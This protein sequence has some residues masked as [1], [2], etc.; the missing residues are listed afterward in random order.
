MDTPKQRRRSVVRPHP[1][2]V[3]ISCCFSALGA[4]CFDHTLGFIP[5]TGLCAMSAVA[6]KLLPA[7]RGEQVRRDEAAD[8]EQLQTWCEHLKLPLPYYFERRSDFPPSFTDPRERA[9]FNWDT[10]P[11]HF[12][13]RE[14]KDFIHRMLKKITLELNASSCMEQVAEGFEGMLKANGCT[15]HAE[16][17]GPLNATTMRRAMGQWFEGEWLLRGRNM[18][19]DDLLVGMAMDCVFDTGS[20][21]SIFEVVLNA[22]GY[23]DDA[24]RLAE[25]D[26]PRIFTGEAG[27]NGKYRRTLDDHPDFVLVP[28]VDRPPLSEA[29]DEERRRKNAAFVADLFEWVW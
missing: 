12:R 26:C 23:D 9:D 2:A 11:L 27:S 28:F 4:D 13:H 22:L 20:R 29:A 1:D 3:P 10:S 21:D 19:L 16:T 15:D 8:A 18:Y 6:K 14:M 25:I 5:D 17:D 7:V 24:P